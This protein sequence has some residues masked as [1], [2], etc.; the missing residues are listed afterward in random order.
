MNDDQ[1]MTNQSTPEKIEDRL[2]R[3][4]VIR[5]ALQ[6]E[7]ELLHSLSQS[8]LGK[9]IELEI[10]LR[11]TSGEVREYIGKLESAIR[12]AM[13]STKG[14]INLECK[15]HELD[16]VIKELADLAFR[17]RYSVVVEPI[18]IFENVRAA[19]HAAVGGGALSI[20]R[21]QGTPSKSQVEAFISEERHRR[22]TGAPHGLS[23]NVADTIP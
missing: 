2:I 7:N 18:E 4:E 9:I 5:Q 11:K 21:I 6:Q 20:D 14:R 22:S 15:P 3:S 19:T 1:P 8:R 16:K 17:A 13:N 23:S 10:Q 12:A